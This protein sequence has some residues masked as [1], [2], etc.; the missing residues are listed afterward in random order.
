MADLMAL[1]TAT[2][3]GER[4]V[5]ELCDR[6]GRQTYL[7]AADALLARTRAAVQR[8]IVDKL[9]ESPQSFED[10]VDDDGLGN[11][12]FRIKLAVWRQGERAIFDFTGHRHRPRVSINFYLHDGMMK[13]VIGVYLIMVFDPDVLFNEGFYDLLEIRIEEGSLLRPRYPAPLGIRHSTKCR[14]GSTSSAGALGRH[15]P[16]TAAAAGCG[17]SPGS[18]LGN[19]SRRRAVRHARNPHGRRPGT[20]AGDGL[21]ARRWYPQLE[22]TPAQYRETYYP[23]VVEESGIVPDWA[24]PA[25]TAVAAARARSCASWSQARCRSTTIATS[26][27]HGRCAEAGIM[28]VAHASNSYDR[29]AAARTCPQRSTSSRCTPATS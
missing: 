11:G 27:T 12:P 29:T 7:E 8:L 1:C 23:V 14:A 19:E 6:F 10:F 15:V 13:M 20:P 18:S 25:T 3:M 16:E 26:P 28:A 22:N 2:A 5:I 24:V 21:D 17:S 4:R 9:P